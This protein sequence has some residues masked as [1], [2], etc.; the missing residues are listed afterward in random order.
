MGKK[1]KVN[2]KFFPTEFVIEDI[3]NCRLNEIIETVNWYLSMEDGS[4]LSE[5][6]TYTISNLFEQNPNIIKLICVAFEEKGYDSF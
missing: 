2:K 6:D 5:N 4:K 3:E 1:K